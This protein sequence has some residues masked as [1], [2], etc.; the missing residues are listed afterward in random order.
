MKVQKVLLL[1]LM[2]FVCGCSGTGTD[3]NSALEPPERK[4][5]YFFTHGYLRDAFFSNPEQL[6][7]TLKTDGQQYLRGLWLTESGGDPADT[8]DITCS[9]VRDDADYLI[10]IVQ[11]PEPVELTDA[12]YVALILNNEQPAYF[13][14]EKTIDFSNSGH[15][16]VLCGWTESAHR[17]YG[18]TTADLSEK[19]FV[20]RIKKIYK[21][22]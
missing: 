17:N 10:I 19:S 8:N 15:K 9:V 2:I 4:A 14:L 11:P 18:L 16:A 22:D 7:S 13:T 5:R 20:D 21:I 6:M 3:K 12:Y 1:I